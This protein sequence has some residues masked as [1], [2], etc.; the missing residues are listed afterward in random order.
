MVMLLT[1]DST[2]PDS[3]LA[4]AGERFDRLMTIESRPL[5]GGLP[6]GLVVPMYEICR[7]LS[8]GAFFTDTATTEIYTVQCVGS[9]RRV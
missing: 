5:S 7:R 2:G 3:L 1:E 4:M 8:D 9:V 6:P